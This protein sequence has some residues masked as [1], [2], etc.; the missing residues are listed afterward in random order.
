MPSSYPQ[1][2]SLLE[3]LLDTLESLISFLESSSSS[4]RAPNRVHQ[5]ESTIGDGQ[6]AERQHGDAPPKIFLT[7]TLHTPDSAG[8]YKRTT[9]KKNRSIQKCI[10]VATWGAFFAAAVYAGIAAR[11]WST[12]QDQLE[13]SE[14]S[15]IKI[16]VTVSQIGFSGLKVPGASPP[17]LFTPIKADVSGLVYV[18]YKLENFGHSP[19]LRVEIWDDVVLT[20]PKDEVFPNTGISSAPI[21]RQKELCDRNTQGDTNYLLPE[22]GAIFPGQ[23][24]E[25]EGH[26]IPLTKKEIE[27]AIQTGDGN[28]KFIEPVVVGCVDYILSF[29]PPK[30]HQTG[31]ALRIREPIKVG[32]DVSTGLETWTYGR[33]EYAN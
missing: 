13:S 21:A 2:S 30:H 25:P 26:A 11:Q 29:G 32:K 4:Y 15:W 7:A 3:D 27:S 24:V 28:T 18:N 14:R 8:R 9:D 12:A 17:I 6:G 10:A 5:N 1:K 23:T 31:F 22:I 16:D 33:G 20:S 19:S